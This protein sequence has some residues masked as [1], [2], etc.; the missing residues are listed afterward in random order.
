MMLNGG[1]GDREYFKIYSPREWQF[2]RYIL[3]QVVLFSEPGPILDVGAGLGFI[4]EG[5]LRWGL[6]CTG[7]EGSREAVELARKRYPSVVMEQH[8]L[9]EPFPLENDRYQT[10]IM[11]QVVEHLEPAVARNALAEAF[12]V[13]RPGGLLIVYS[14]SRFNKEQQKDD[15]THINM[16]SPSELRDVVSSSGFVDITACD[17]PL[18]LLGKGWF[19]KGLMYT[20]FTVAR[21]E[22]LSATANCRAYKPTIAAT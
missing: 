7:L 13:M 10:V 22:R 19:G 9:S 8:L 5:A 21:W 20:I 12:R 15:K 3:S 18:D 14:P 2:Y 4:V 17:V 6:E 16:L 11:N 1:I